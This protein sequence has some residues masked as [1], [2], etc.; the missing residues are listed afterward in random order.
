[1]WLDSELIASFGSSYVASL[2]SSSSTLLPSSS[3]G[4]LTGIGS[5]KK[6]KRSQ[7]E[8]KLG[9]FF[10]HQIESDGSVAYRDGFKRGT[11]V[12][13]Q[14][15]VFAITIMSLMVIGPRAHVTKTMISNYEVTSCK[16][17]TPLQGLSAW[18][19]TNYQQDFM[20]VAC[21]TAQ[22]MILA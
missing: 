19:S 22:I 4:S 10:K 7:F 3:L 12:A 15:I 14:G 5:S 8:R 1:M 21:I 6:G 17:T 13:R 2:L 16:Q 11:D 18:T 9:E 20:N